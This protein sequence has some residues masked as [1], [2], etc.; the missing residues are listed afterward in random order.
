M[1]KTSANGKTRTR[2]FGSAKSLADFDPLNF[3]LNGE[4]FNCKPAIQGQAM[5]TFVAEA[6]S[7]DGGKAATA[8]YGFFEK[9]LIPDD[10]NKFEGML[11]SDEYI[12]DLGLI[13]DIAAW[14]VEEYTARPTSEPKS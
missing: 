7:E 6:D 11:R 5:L 1:T 13:G 3:T 12:V 4:T 14:L 2:D 8:L 10:Y 9:A